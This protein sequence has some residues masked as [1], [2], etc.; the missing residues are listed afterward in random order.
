MATPA[1][2]TQRLRAVRSLLELTQAEEALATA[3]RR[4][5]AAQRRVETEHGRLKT[6]RAAHARE[7]GETFSVTPEEVAAGATGAAAS[8]ADGTAESSLDMKRVHKACE[9]VGHAWSNGWRLKVSAEQA[10]YARS[11]VRID[12]DDTWRITRAPARTFVGLIN[13]DK[14][15]GLDYDTALSEFKPLVC[16]VRDDTPDEVWCPVCGI[17]VIGRGC[18]DPD[19]GSADTFHFAC[20]AFVAMC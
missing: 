5:E 7:F 2:A 17:L 20:A 13:E 18:W 1:T 9:D 4:V 8:A 10:E 14:W 3:Q 16:R 12:A 15:R 11:Y 6:M 19:V